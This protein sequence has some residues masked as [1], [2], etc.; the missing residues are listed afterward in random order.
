LPD[1]SRRRGGTATAACDPRD[2]RLLL[3]V[4]S[5]RVLTGERLPLGRRRL[6]F[7]ALRHLGATSASARPASSRSTRRAQREVDERG[8]TNDDAV[9]RTGSTPGAALAERDDPAPRVRRTARH[10]R[11]ALDP[12]STS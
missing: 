10:D 7:A 9:D 3:S 8:G 1:R 6:L 5:R 2:R 12:S 4:S 11:A